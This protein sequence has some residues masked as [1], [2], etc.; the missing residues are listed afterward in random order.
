[1]VTV[2]KMEK[3]ENTGDIL[4]ELRGLEDDVKPTSINGGKIENGSTFIEIDTGDEYMYDLENTT[5]YKIASGNG[6]SEPMQKYD[7][8]IPAG[9]YEDISGN[10][11]DE[12]V[13]AVL[14]EIDANHLDADNNVKPLLIGIYLGNDEQSKEGYFTNITQIGSADGHVVLKYVSDIDMLYHGT[15]GYLEDNWYVT[16]SY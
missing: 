4:V 3:K 2:Y 15:I 8:I 13:I 12:G 5:W 10:I 1:M 11:N 14:E 9:L 16:N 6:G 7:Y